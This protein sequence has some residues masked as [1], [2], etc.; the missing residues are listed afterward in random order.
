MIK[1]RTRLI[2]LISFSFMLHTKVR[3][4]LTILVVLWTVV[5][6]LI[7]YLSTCWSSRHCRPSII[8]QTNL[9]VKPVTGSWPVNMSNKNFDIV[10]DNELSLAISLTDFILFGVDCC[11]A[12]STVNYSTVQQAVCSCARDLSQSW[13]QLGSDAGANPWPFTTISVPITRHSYSNGAGFCF[14]D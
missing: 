9:R 13:W 2:L 8:L 6:A 7:V 3:T 4:A 11:L 12:T 1:E 5:L 10:T 14:S